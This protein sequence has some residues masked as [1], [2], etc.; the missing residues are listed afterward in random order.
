MNDILIFPNGESLVLKALQLRI[1][2][3]TFTT[4]LDLESSQLNKLASTGSA[5][6][7]VDEGLCSAD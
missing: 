5:P 2:T 4:L 7:G 6:G 3:R 1:L